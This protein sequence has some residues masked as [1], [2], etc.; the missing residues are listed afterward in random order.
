MVRTFSLPSGRVLAPVL[1]VLLMLAPWQTADADQNAPRLDSLFGKLLT[2][3]H[4]G[5]ARALTQQIW[6]IW[7]KNHDPEVEKHMTVGLDAMEAGDFHCA[8]TELV[9]IL[10]G[11]L[12]LRKEA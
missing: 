5:T 9:P 11:H 8:L 3:E 1:F 2:T 6:D 12:C 7:T 10:T 4:F